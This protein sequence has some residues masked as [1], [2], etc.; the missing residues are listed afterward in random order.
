MR[1]LCL[2]E[3]ALAGI[4]L[5]LT[6]VICH[7]P[8]SVSVLRSPCRGQAVTD[9]LNLQC[10]MQSK[11]LTHSTVCV[12]RGDALVHVAIQDSRLFL[13]GLRVL[14]VH[15]AGGRKERDSVEI[16]GQVRDGACH[17][18]SHAIVQNSVTGPHLTLKEAGKDH[19]QVCACKDGEHRGW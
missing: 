17:L 18:C 12:G 7:E 4:D 2:R 11:F 19:R 16:H 6:L 13:S 3:V 9:T 1:K 8:F 10:L 15:P 14:S 5:T